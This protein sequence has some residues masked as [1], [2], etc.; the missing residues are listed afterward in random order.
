VD[1]A[2]LL[3]VFGLSLKYCKWI[4]KEDTKRLLATLFYI[5]QRSQFEMQVPFKWLTLNVLAHGLLY[6]A[7]SQPFLLC[8]IQNQR[9]SKFAHFCEWFLQMKNTRI[10]VKSTWESSQATNIYCLY[11]WSVQLYLCYFLTLN[12]LKHVGQWRCFVEHQLLMHY[13]AKF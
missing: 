2:K 12:M 5:P 10:K 3:K 11:M 9:D 13:W 7:F 8:L 6:F 4:V 1:V